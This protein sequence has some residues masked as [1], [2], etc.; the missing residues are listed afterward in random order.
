MGE[1]PRSRDIASIIALVL[2]NAMPLIGV[3]WFHWQVFPILLVYW[4]ENVVIGGFNVLKMLTADPEQPIAW[5]GKLFLIPFFCVHFGLFTMIHGM[6]V[7]SFFGREVPALQA[8]HYGWLTPS[9]VATAVHATHI[10][11]AWLALL[12]SHG[13]SFVWNYLLGGEYKNVGLQVLMNQPYARVIVLH[14]V[15]LFGAGLTTALG[16]PT[17][18]LVLLV[19]LKIG[20]DV[21]AHRRERTKLGA[22]ALPAS[23][24]E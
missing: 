19:G 12:L 4:L 8:L 22:P 7:F 21:R 3:L 10:E 17:P 23:R 18:A 5:V 6:L 9:V 14:I 13:F 20:M 2:A 11:Y 24:S 1:A 16:S 15:I